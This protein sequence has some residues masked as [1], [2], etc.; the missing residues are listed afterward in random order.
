MDDPEMRGALGDEAD[1]LRSVDVD[2]VERTDATD[3][4]READRPG[5]GV[6]REGF[7][8]SARRGEGFG[9]PSPDGRLV[10]RPSRGET[11]AERRDEEA[12]EARDELEIGRDPLH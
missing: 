4:A 8:G 2:V 10:T 7:S 5:G 1:A 9:R 11:G 6:V 3:E 12:T